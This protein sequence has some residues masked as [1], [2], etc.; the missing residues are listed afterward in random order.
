MLDTTATTI[1]DQQGVPCLGATRALSNDASWEASV[2]HSNIEFTRL[3]P[4]VEKQE[5]E[6]HFVLGYN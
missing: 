6:P 2:V 3:I 1:I 4:R 5:A